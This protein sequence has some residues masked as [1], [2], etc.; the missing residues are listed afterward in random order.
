MTAMN[1]PQEMPATMLSPAAADR[2]TAVGSESLFVQQGWYGWGSPVGLG[3]GLLC[4]G[5]FFVLLALGLAI[6]A[7]IG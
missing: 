6:L 1:D 7:S 2:T 4:V 3:L 5:S